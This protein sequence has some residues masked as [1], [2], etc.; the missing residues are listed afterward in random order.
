MVA[1]D[2]FEDDCMTRM[3]MTALELSMQ[4]NASGHQSLNSIE[5]IMADILLPLHF[6]LEHKSSDTNNCYVYMTRMKMT[7]HE[8]KLRRIGDRD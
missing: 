5:G 8:Q 3:K 6:I 1:N 2:L 4:C 7:W